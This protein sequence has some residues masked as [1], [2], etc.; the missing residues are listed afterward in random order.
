MT[1]R[2]GAPPLPGSS[3]RMEISEMEVAVE[4]AI[5]DFHAP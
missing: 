4:I 2:S 1:Y 5:T 3:A